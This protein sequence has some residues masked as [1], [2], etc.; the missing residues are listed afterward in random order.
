ME[1]HEFD[2]VVQR[3]LEQGTA[4]EGRGFVLMPSASPIGRK[5]SPRTLRN[6]EAIVRRVKQ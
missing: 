2:H 1:P 6:Y 3:T 4:G 5:L